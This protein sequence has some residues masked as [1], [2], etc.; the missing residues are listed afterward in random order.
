MFS[1]IVLYVSSNSSLCFQQQCFMFSTIV[2]LCF[3]AIVRLCLQQWGHQCG[4]D[5]QGIEGA[6]ATESYQQ[7]K[8]T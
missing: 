6:E 5:T 8:R 1:A 7:G 2:Q 4:E 3:L